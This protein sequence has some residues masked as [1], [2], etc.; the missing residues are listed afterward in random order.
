[1]KPLPT[2][3]ELTKQL[4]LLSRSL[5]KLFSTKRTYHQ[6]MH[7]AGNQLQTQP[8]A[9]TPLSS[10]PARQEMCTAGCSVE[11]AALPAAPRIDAAHGAILNVPTPSKSAAGI[12]QSLSATADTSS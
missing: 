4:G 8:Q 12:P 1:M 3:V 2:A 9:R 5:T 10:Q 11:A 6:S 7:R